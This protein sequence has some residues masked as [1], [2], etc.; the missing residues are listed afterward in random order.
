MGP[1]ARPVLVDVEERRARDVPLEVQLASPPGRA[2]LPATVD[3]LVGEGNGILSS[4]AALRLGS[5]GRGDERDGRKFQAFLRFV[6]LEAQCEVRPDG[7][8]CFVL[9]PPERH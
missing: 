2:E 3:E 6:G 4:L 5:R 1:A 8:T 7:G 9:E